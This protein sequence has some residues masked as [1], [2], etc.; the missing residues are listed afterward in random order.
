[1]EAVVASSLKFSTSAWRFGKEFSRTA[2]REFYY[3]GSPSMQT[4]ANLWEVLCRDLESQRQSAKADEYHQVAQNFLD[5]AHKVLRPDSPHLCD[6]VEIAGD[7]CQAAG[8]L[9]DAAANF[10]TA[11]KKNQAIGVS[12]A[13]ARLGA[14][15]ALL[16]EQRGETTTAIAAYQRALGLYEEANDRSEHLMLL[17]Q[18]GSLQKRTADLS[19]A[20]K[21]YQRAMDVATILHG[22]RDPEVATAANNLAVTYTEML[23]F[24][25]AE[26]L[27][28]QALAIRETTYGPMHPEV[29]QSMANLAVVYH[30]QGEANKANGYYTGALQI[31]ARFRPNDDPEVQTVRENHQALLDKLAS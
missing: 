25:R 21:S 22:E 10:E 24:V 5:A 31:F 14:K 8:R 7:I 29:A 12:A 20:E 27:H 26:N 1:M 2:A 18:L 13:S 28:M 17:N 16:A 15:L 9:D 3:R 11:L 23:D 19:G 6:A 30:A 4:T